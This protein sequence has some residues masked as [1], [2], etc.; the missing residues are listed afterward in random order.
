MST[1]LTHKETELLNLLR[2]NARATVSDLAKALGLSRPTVQNMMKKLET[3][4]IQ[5]YTLELKPGFA[6]ASIRAFVLLN[7]DPKKSGAIVDVL[8]KY[9]TV[10]YVCT[11]AGEFDVL[12]ELE[13][14]HYDDLEEILNGIAMI[15]GVAR[16]Q[17][18]MVLAEK[19]SQ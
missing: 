4:A 15:D 1:T 18:F 13:A 16:T 6:N 3:V 19:F 11:V 9:P 12:I 5:R 10:K 8:S 7:R 2:D 14:D 17:T